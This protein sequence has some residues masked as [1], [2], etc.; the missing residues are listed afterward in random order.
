M[1]T[2][3]MTRCVGL[4]LIGWTTLSGALAQVSDGRTAVV[5]VILDNRVQL[6]K[7]GPGAALEGKLERAVYWRDQEVFPAGSRVRMVVDQVVSQ[8]KV[9]AV[10]DRPFFIHLFAPRHERVAQFRSARVTLPWGE[11]IPLRAV[12]LALSER[13]E[14]RARPGTPVAGPANAERNPSRN[15]APSPSSKK[16]PAW[17][18]TLQVEPKSASFPTLARARAARVPG[19]VPA[20]VQPCTVA[21]GTRLS[22]VLLAGLSASKN[23]EGQT[24]QAL[25]LE[26]V[27]AGSSVAI[28]QGA[29]VQGTLA[30][31]VPPRRLYR[32]ASMNLLFTRVILPG[33][34][35]IAVSASPMAAE[36]D[37]GTHMTM[38]AEGRIHAM[39]PGK[40]R[41]L[42]DFGVTGGISKVADD[43]TQ[44]IIEAISSTA[45]DASTAG[46]AR[47]AALGA[48]AIY[49]LTRHG[50]DVILPPF[51]E[52]DL[53]L[54]RDVSMAGGPSTTPQSP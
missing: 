29:I 49:M 50:R 46:V 11:E 18:L 8:E 35:A 19:A 6:N 4:A 24:F 14:L 7:T 37:R 2:S 23:H 36:V 22:T 32:P 25:L 40:A 53:S 13:A 48:S 52:M 3:L 51:T 43:T 42:F 15:A 41:F 17:V 34:G 20:C 9:D 38:D 33:G 54:T 39:N 45:T 26:P 31:S 27:L 12:F 16:P 1:R 44:L 47:I 21:G 5:W 30:K 10:D 28:P